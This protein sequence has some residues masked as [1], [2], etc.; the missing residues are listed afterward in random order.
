MR[1]DRR[2]VCLRQDSGL[3]LTAKYR[4]S[5]QPQKPEK[6]DEVLRVALNRKR[7][8]LTRLY[9]SLSPCA[10]SASYSISKGAKVEGFTAT[11]TAKCR[12]AR[13]G[14]SRIF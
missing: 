12:M 10:R 4:N 5:A 13:S 8:T 11:E 2:T 1:R 7:H 6:T 3:G 9:A 14:L